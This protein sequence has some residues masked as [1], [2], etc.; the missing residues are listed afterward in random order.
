MCGGYNYGERSRATSK[1]CG[2]EKINGIINRTSH[3]PIGARDDFAR[4][5]INDLPGSIIIENFLYSPGGQ[6]FALCRAGIMGIRM[7]RRG[8]F[9]HQGWIKLILFFV[10]CYNCD[11]LPE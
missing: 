8:G 10:L 9:V 1:R 7:I 4:G 6:Y 5:V 2:A 3:Y 11:R